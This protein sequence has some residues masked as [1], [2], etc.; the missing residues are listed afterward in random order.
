MVVTSCG[1]GAT[2]RRTKVPGGAGRTALGS[3]H[4]SGERGRHDHRVLC[5]SGLT[6]AEAAARLAAD[7]PNA[8]PSPRRASPVV[9]LLREMTHF[10]GGRPSTPERGQ[11]QVSGPINVCY[12]TVRDGMSG[13][14]CPGRAAAALR[15]GSAS[16]TIRA[17]QSSR[18]RR[19]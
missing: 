17:A 12:V 18:G 8:L 9:L 3:P 6:S 2:G 7:G 13:R 11:P 5:R 15:V 4:D 16:S 1:T 19:S 14:R 10:L